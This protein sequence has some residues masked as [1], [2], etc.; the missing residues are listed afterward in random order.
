MARLARA[1][2]LASGLAMFERPWVS[3]SDVMAG[4]TVVCLVVLP[5][6]FMLHVLAP[7]PAFEQNV[8][9]IGIFRGIGIVKDVQAKTGALTLDHQEITGCM[10]AMEMMF[11]VESPALSADLRPG[12]TIAFDID[13][14]RYTIIGVQRVAQAAQASEVV[15]RP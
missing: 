10:A 12:D 3:R 1:A 11:R 15:A 4:A 7:T 9:A 6:A 14:A 5:G 8:E 2:F 13:A